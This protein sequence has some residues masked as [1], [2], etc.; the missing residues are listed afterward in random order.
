MSAAAP[1]L[2]PSAHIKTRPAVHRPRRRPAAPRLAERMILEL[3]SA[4]DVRS[5]VTHIAAML[6]REGGAARVEWWAPTGDGNALRLEVADGGA[7]G[8][9]IAV[10]VGPAGVLVL[11]GDRCGTQL[12]PVVRRV[13][14]VLRRR[15]VEEK[16]AGQA[17]RLA[18]RNEALEDFAA[19]VA[20]ELKAPLLAAARQEDAPAGIA[21]ALDIVDE[22]LELAR[23]EDV[24]TVCAPGECLDGALD[25]LGLLTAEVDSD[26]PGAFPLPSTALRLFLRNLVANAAAA[27]ARHVRISAVA[28]AASTTLMVDDDGIG[29]A[30]T[31]RYAAGSGLGFRLCK[32]VAARYGGELELSARVGGGTRAT[33]KI[34]RA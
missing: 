31:S 17:A 21:C 8:R 10:P 12:V 20:H 30:D 23:G 18:R 16:L 29:L 22:L 24:A 27:G 32:R 11:T 5:G 14:P 13:A 4:E 15:F 2:F 7:V 34:E 9:R 1:S 25:D 3:A 26:L 19:L 33:L 28:S 6:R